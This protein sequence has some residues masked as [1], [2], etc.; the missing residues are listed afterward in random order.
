[1]RESTEI[2]AD[3]LLQPILPVRHPIVTALTARLRAGL[4]PMV[5]PR[6][7]PERRSLAFVELPSFLDELGPD[8]GDSA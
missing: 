6:E 4:K 3:H 5:G 2:A 7:Q 8:V 1:M